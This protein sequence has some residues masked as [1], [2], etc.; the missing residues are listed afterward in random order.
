MA[1]IVN[2]YSTLQAIKDLLNITAVNTTD[3]GVLNSLVNA[4]SRYIDDYTRRT[5]YPR[6]AELLLDTPRGRKLY[7]PDDLLAIITLTN[8]DA[9]VLTTA[10]Y[11]LEPANIYPKWAIM[12]KQSSTKFWST[13]AYNNTEQVIS[14]EG[15]WGCRQRY[16]EHAWTLGSTLNEGGVLNA[17][18]TTFTVTSGTLFNAGNIIKIEDE[19]MNVASKSTNDITVNKRGDNGSTAATHAD[20]LPVYIWSVEPAVELAF[21]MIVRNFYHNRFGQNTTGISQITAAGVV[22]APE[23]IPKSAINMLDPFVRGA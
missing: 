18:D 12:F 4:A 3:D 6:I 1:N 11:L 9:E 22:L 17:T 8:G 20:T 15:W 16:A 7:L 5:F 13:D 23:D 14:V 2:G 21:Q 10:D 19:I